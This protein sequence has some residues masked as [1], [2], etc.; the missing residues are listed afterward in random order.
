[1]TVKR[2]YLREHSSTNLYLS[3]LLKE[4]PETG[5]VVVV[6]DYQSEGRGQGTRQWQ[7]NAGE[8]LLLSLLLFPAVLSASDQF[9]LSRIAALA[10]IDMLG[11]LQLDANIKWPN[12]ILVN[13]KKLAGILIENGITGKYLSHSIIGIGLNVNQAVFSDFPIKAASLATESGD[14]FDREKILDR[15]LD[16]LL[17]RYGQLEKGAGGVLEKDYLKHLFLK[18]QQAQFME[19]EKQFTGIIRGI[20]ELG[21]LV[22]ERDG[23]SRTYAFQE[24]RYVPDWE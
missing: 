13:R 1:M 7:S 22:M 9:Q 11:D 15:L 6:A 24:I 2:V 16:A 14:S 20:S 17:F 5:P 12:D 8:N 18:D 4:N 23:L 3:E 10:L 21:E 19:G